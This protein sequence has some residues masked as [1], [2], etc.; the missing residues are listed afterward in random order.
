MTHKWDRGTSKGFGDRHEESGGNNSPGAERMDRHNNSWGRE[1]G[2]EFKGR[3][4]AYPSSEARC[5]YRAKHAHSM[6]YPGA[7]L[8]VLKF[9]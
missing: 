5:E 4:G 9:R 1:W 6:E 8:W 7:V 2:D 3:D